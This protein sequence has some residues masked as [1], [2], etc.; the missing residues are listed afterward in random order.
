[1]PVEQVEIGYVAKPHGIAGE[2]RVVLHNSA[3][4]ILYEVDEVIVRTNVEQSECLRIESARPAADGI[5]L[6]RLECVRSR[7]DALPFRGA[8]LLVPRAALPKEADD[9][10]YVHD[11]IG[12]SVSCRDGTAIG[13]VLDYVSYPTADVMVVG[14]SARYEIPMIDDFIV[15]VDVANKQI[16][17]V[18]AVYDFKVE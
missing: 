18:D 2:L 10:F 13:H 17:V 9:E 15:S 14:G 3:S 8:R 6:L 7:T 11:I 1:M 4:R 16:I 12:A 5:V